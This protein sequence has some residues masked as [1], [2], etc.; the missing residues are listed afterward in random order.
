[1]ALDLHQALGRPTDHSADSTYQGHRSW[2]DWWADLLAAVRN[3]QMI[4]RYRGEAQQDP[5]TRGEAPQPLCG[6]CCHPY[7]PGACPLCST[8][9]A[10]HDYTWPGQPETEA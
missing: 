5:A 3:A 9:D 10:R 7:H 2:G 4:R 6:E 8:A 1:M